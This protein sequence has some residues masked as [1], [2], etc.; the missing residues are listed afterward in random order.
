MENV[1][2]KEKTEKLAKSIRDKKYD[3][4]LRQSGIN[5]SAGIKRA[6][7][8][9]DTAPKIS[10]IPSENIEKS[11]IISTIQD[12]SGKADESA[13]LENTPAME[14]LERTANEKVSAETAQK[15][16][17]Y[18][19]SIS[20]AATGK[21]AS[22]SAAVFEAAARTSEE[23]AAE[24]AQKAQKYYSSISDSATGKSA[25]ESAE[26]FENALKTAEEKQTQAAAETLKSKGDD[27]LQSASEKISEGIKNTGDDAAKIKDKIN[28]SSIKQKAKTFIKEK[29][30]P[31]TKTK[32]FKYGAAAAAVIATIATAV[33]IAK[34]N[35]DKENNSKT[36]NTVR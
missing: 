11:N 17:K 1:E 29:A 33:G 12:I 19:S 20:D 21:S 3:D 30:I 25:K 34:N 24:T 6:N 16:Q 27:V 28:L 2:I 10:E 14:A 15:A 18:Y 23:T 26:I 31:F 5:A 8:L 35:A 32:K 7:T 36:I 13:V 22:E 4:A 9:Q